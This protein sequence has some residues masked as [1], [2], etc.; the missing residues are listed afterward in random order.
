VQFDTAK[1]VPHIGRRLRVL[2]EKSWEAMMPEAEHFIPYLLLVALTAI[3]AWTLFRRIGMAPAWTLLSLVP[4]GMI[5]IL[6]IVAYRRWPNGE[7]SN[8]T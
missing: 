5:V 7:P 1:A 3:P 6:W 2:S 4:A 8:R